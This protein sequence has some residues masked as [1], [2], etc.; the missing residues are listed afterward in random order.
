MADALEALIVRVSRLEQERRWWQSAALIS[1][2]GAG[3]MMGALVLV[4]PALMTPDVI[5]AEQ[6]VVRDADG[7]PRGVLAVDA[8]DSVSL[9]LVDREGNA[10]E[11]VLGQQ[12]SSLSFQREGRTRALLGVFPNENVGLSLAGRG[13]PETVKLLVT[14]DG[15]SG[16]AFGKDGTP[17]AAFGLTPRGAPVLS[18]SD[19]PRNPAAAR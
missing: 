9:R 3:L 5:E 18:F 12:G 13:E 8:T 11:L 14:A 16:L 4:P 17:R 15:A 6:L 10:T 19:R 2:L 7:R 1:F